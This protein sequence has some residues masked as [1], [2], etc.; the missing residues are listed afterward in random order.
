MESSSDAGPGPG[1][2]EE[3]SESGLGVGTSEAV[4]ADSSDAAAAPG[5]AEADDSEVGQSSD[6]GSR[7]RVWAVL[8]GVGGGGDPGPPRG[9]R[10][11]R[12]MGVWCTGRPCRGLAR[13]LR[14]PCR[15][16]TTLPHRA[17][18]QA[19]PRVP[20]EAEVF[21]AVLALWE[22]GLLVH[23]WPPPPVYG[24]SLGLS[25]PACKTEREYLPLSSRP[26]FSWKHFVRPV[27]SRRG[28][29]PGPLP[30]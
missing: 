30:P 29:S 17:E 10:L 6:R 7:S 9:G 28:R 19:G 24:A 26:T 21:P 13:S 11:V 15:A 8:A 14:S 5:P 20:A 27:S 22:A 4:S 23:V 3:P 16:Q 12:S 1:R 25:L 2:P 18:K